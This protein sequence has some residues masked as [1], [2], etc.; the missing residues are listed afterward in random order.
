MAG[1]ATGASRTRDEPWWPH[2]ATPRTREVSVAGWRPASPAAGS[3]LG[4]RSSQ[5]PPSAVAAIRYRSSSRGASPCQDCAETCRASPSDRARSYSTGI[6]V[7]V[8]PP[9]GIGRCRM[10]VLPAATQATLTSFRDPERAAGQ[11]GHH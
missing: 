3:G 11:Q 5:I 7:E 4:V 2:N 9:K 10:A 8:R 1:S 6:A